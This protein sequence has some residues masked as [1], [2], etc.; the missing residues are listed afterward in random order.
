MNEAASGAP[1]DILVERPAEGVIRITLR[2][3]EVRNALRTRA[4]RPTSTR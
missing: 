3:P 2:R 1:Q 4:R